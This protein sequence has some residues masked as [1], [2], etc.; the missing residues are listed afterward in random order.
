VCRALRVLCASSNDDGL[1]KLKKAA[2]SA[3][4]EVV[5]GAASL[6]E[7][8][9]QLGEW[10]PDVVVIDAAMGSEAVRA[11]REARPAIRIVTLGPLLAGEDAAAETLLD[12]RRAMLGL[13]RTGGPVR[14]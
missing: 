14:W 3:H 9:K 12:V 10:N 1:S 8:V 13:P 5:G 2:V 11:V 6:D 7:L 4:W